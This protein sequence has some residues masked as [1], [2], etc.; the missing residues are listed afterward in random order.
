MN[1][2]LENLVHRVLNEPVYTGDLEIPSGAAFRLI[3]ARIP[4]LFEA[5]LVKEDKESLEDL[6]V[7]VIRL[8]VLANANMNPQAKFSQSPEYK[9]ALVEYQKRASQGD[10]QEE[11]VHLVAR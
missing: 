6:S 2:A 8:L 1:F 5:I 7:A 4:K 9:Q 11:G 10:T 3:L